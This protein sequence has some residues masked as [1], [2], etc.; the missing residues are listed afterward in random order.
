VNNL[1]SHAASARHLIVTKL[2]QAQPFPSRSRTGW[3]FCLTPAEHSALDGHAWCSP[4]LLPKVCPASADL[5]QRPGLC[6]AHCATIATPKSAVDKRRGFHS[7]P[8]LRGLP[9]ARRLSSSRSGFSLWI[10]VRLSLDKMACLV[11][12]AGLALTLL[13][14]RVAPGDRGL[15]SGVGTAF[16]AVGCLAVLKSSFASRRMFQSIVMRREPLLEVLDFAATKN[17]AQSDQLLSKVMTLVRSG[18]V[19]LY[20]EL[21]SS[22]SLEPIPLEYFNN[23][24]LTRLNG[25]GVRTSDPKKLPSDQDTDD[26]YFEIYAPISLQRMLIQI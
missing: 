9:E 20:G 7:P 2:Q 18:Q 11:G 10:V 21:G 17:P 23:H 26:C 24:E 19:T 13:P 4:T 22:R 14:N 6:G 8:N 5:R 16:L 1:S 25:T 15:L 12:L 3:G